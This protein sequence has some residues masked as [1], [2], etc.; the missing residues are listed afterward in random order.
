MEIIKQGFMWSTRQAI[1]LRPQAWK[2]FLG[3]TIGG[4]IRL[5]IRASQISYCILK[6]V[7]I[8]K[9]EAYFALGRS[10]DLEKT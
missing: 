7:V 8:G 10:K 3:L 2:T 9:L 6:L 1:I 5:D 4:T